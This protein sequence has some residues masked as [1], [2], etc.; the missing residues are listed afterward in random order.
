MIVGFFAPAVSAESDLNKS[1]Y[2]N[3]VY[4]EG[5]AESYSER[6]GNADSTHRSESRHANRVART[7]KAR[8]EE[9][10]RRFQYAGNEGDEARSR[11]ARTIEG[12]LPMAGA[13]ISG[14][15]VPLAAVR[16]YQQCVSIVE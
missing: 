2:L 14:D 6:L 5:V 15:D 7:L 4:C 10:V 16:Q 1:F 8:A 11:G 9:M 12:M 3:T 13:W